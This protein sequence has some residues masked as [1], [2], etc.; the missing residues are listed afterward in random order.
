[1]VEISEANFSLT[2]VYQKA[3]EGG[4]IGYIAEIDGI[5]TQGETLE[6]TKE[7]LLDAYNFMVECRKEEMKDVLSNS[8]VQPFIPT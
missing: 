5:N 3:A 8:I 4:Y 7:N 6:E 1:M 2:A